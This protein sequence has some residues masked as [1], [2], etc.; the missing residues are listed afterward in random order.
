MEF[1]ETPRFWYPRVLLMRGPIFPFAPTKTYDPIS[2]D[3]RENQRKEKKSWL[4]TL[5]FSHLPL[6]FF[7]FIVF[8]FVVVFLFYFDTWRNVDLSFG[9]VS[10]PKKFI[11]FQFNLV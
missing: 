5:S 6:P 7:P 2:V 10:T 1:D 8:D 3:L 11:S 4:F 9:S